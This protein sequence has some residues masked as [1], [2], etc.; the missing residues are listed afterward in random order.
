MR[1]THCAN[2]RGGH[3]GH[4]GAALAAAAVLGLVLGLWLLAGAVEAVVPL[5]PPLAVA[6]P[7]L[8]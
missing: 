4:E 7:V 2:R 6:G 3:R 8:P 1:A 5:L